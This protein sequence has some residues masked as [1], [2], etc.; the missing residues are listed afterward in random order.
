M[1]TTNIN[2]GFN[3]PELE[4]AINRFIP[5]FIN[6]LKDGYQIAK[7]E[8]ANMMFC[9]DRNS[10]K[11]NPEK[12][13]TQGSTNF[14]ICNCSK[15]RCLVITPT[16]E[17]LWACLFYKFTGKILAGAYFDVKE[18]FDVEL[19]MK[20]SKGEFLKRL[21]RTL[22]EVVK[23]ENIIFFCRDSEYILILDR[24]VVKTM[25]LDES[26]SFLEEFK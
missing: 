13:I 19:T 21:N 14:S 9:I 4:Q 1:F 15:S 20:H 12:T 7:D 6:F 8:K 24:E 26:V 16:K 2:L 3:H 10:C 23:D 11:I 17:H 22:R 25:S 18:L 5:Q